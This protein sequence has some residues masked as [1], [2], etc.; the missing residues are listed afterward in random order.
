MPSQQ[1]VRSQIWAEFSPGRHSSRS[2]SAG[3]LFCG[4]GSLGGGSV[5]GQGWGTRI[6]SWS[7]VVVPIRRPSREMK[8]NPPETAR[9]QIDSAWTR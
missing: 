6:W 4:L 2:L 8:T 3:V 9:I 7:R 5:D 1:L